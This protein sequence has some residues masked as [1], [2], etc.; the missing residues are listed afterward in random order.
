MPQPSTQP[1]GQAHQIPVE[2]RAVAE[3]I[4]ARPTRSTKSVKV[5]IM[6]GV[7]RPAPRRMPSATILADTKK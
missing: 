2:P 1:M 6:K 3:R 5:E 7:I 4:F